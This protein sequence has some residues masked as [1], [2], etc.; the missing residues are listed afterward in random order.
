MGVILIADHPGG[1]AHSLRDELTRLGL[2]S[3]SVDEETELIP[4]A[5]V[6]R[7]AAILVSMTLRGGALAACTKLRMAR[8]LESVPILLVSNRRDHELENRVR[9]LKVASHVLYA[10]VE[11]EHLARCLRE[12]GAIDENAVTTKPREDDANETLDSVEIVEVRAPAGPPPRRSTTMARVTEAMATADPQAQVVGARRPPR[13][14]TSSTLTSFRAVTPPHAQPAVDSRAAPSEPD[15][16][17]RLERQIEA[18]RA[19][20]EVTAKRAADLHARLE[21]VE[22][23]RSTLENT[24]RV[25]ED[26]HQRDLDRQRDEFG[27]RLLELESAHRD[28]QRAL[29]SARSE[30]VAATERAAAAERARSSLEQELS[31]S[32]EARRADAR[33][34]SEAHAEAEVARER[35]E[36]AHRAS[37]AAAE[38]AHGHKLRRIES[39]QRLHDVEQLLAE[40]GRALESV[41]AALHES[42]QRVST[43]T[44]TVTRLERELD[45]AR[46]AR[47][48]AEHAHTMERAEDAVRSRDEALARAEAEQA[49]LREEL[50]SANRALEQRARGEADAAREL[51]ERL[52]AQ[53][54]QLAEEHAEVQRQSDAKWMMEVQGRVLAAI[55]LL[56]TDRADA[57]AA[58]RAGHETALSRAEAAWNALRGDLER[59][60][61]ALALEVAKTSDAL[62]DAHERIQSLE[63]SLAERS[64]AHGRAAAEHQRVVEELAALRGSLDNTASEQRRARRALVQ[65]AQALRITIEQLFGDEDP[66]P[67][68]Q[69]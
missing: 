47:E 42:E 26:S 31:R 58:Q 35:A 32:E 52:A 19:D 3:T 37:V 60:I 44:E 33:R 63:T 24:M 2:T 34:A 40:R 4:R 55:T 1:I 64:A 13:P 5:L 15:T 67:S 38:E 29:E 48:R 59:E 27:A 28:T 36:Q 8:G 23:Q 57:L 10:P 56:E 14:A 54:R 50:A 45:D 9:A 39:E 65:Q 51:E 53:A 46:A 49:R 17:V 16:T 43:T 69:G 68:T 62:E 25:I 22:L 30:A 18:L 66:D 61:R 20:R 21:R 7:P 11:R 12:V 41:Q 6:D